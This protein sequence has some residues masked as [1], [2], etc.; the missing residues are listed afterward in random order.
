MSGIILSLLAF[1]I[2]VIFIPDIHGVTETELFLRELPIFRATFML[3]LIFF[4]SGICIA[5][6]REYKVNYVYI[7]GIVAMHKLNQY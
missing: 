2:V 7:F 3:S 1:L 6:F 4:S 5:F